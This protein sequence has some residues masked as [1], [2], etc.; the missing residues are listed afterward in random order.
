MFDFIQHLAQQV[1]A[2]ALGKAIGG[3]GYLF[4]V[5]E[6]I[7][8]VGLALV[9]GSISIVDLRL[10]GLASL[11]RPVT[12]L[13]RQ[14][15]PVTWTGFCI[16]AL[17]GSL[18]FSA[19][20]THYVAVGYFQLKF[21]FLFLAAVNMLIFHVL[22]WKSVAAWDR[23]PR[24]PAMARLAGAVSLCCWIVVVFLGRWVGFAT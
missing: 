20:A 18:M 16:A 1:E 23:Q 5:C 22:T 9:I 19:N 6:V 12:D 17:S 8:V 11:R 2:S 3:S 13:T 10:L 7:H 4:P 14:L 21:V 24:P 15:L